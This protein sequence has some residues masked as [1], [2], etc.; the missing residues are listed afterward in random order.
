M[1]RKAAMT[2]AMLLDAMVMDRNGAQVTKGRSVAEIS[3][4]SG[5]SQ[6]VVRIEIKRLIAAG[7]CR[8]GMEYRM[9]ICGNTR[10]VPVYYVKL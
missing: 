2:E 6:P 10:R 3:E 8:V 9:Q 1:K 7:K 5:L 4:A